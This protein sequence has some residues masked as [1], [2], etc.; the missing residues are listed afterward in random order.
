[1]SQDHTLDRPPGS[2]RDRR[3]SLLLEELFQALPASRQSFSWGVCDAEYAFRSGILVVR[4]LDAVMPNGFH[5]IRDDD[6][7]RLDLRPLPAGEH[8]VYLAMTLC[9]PDE[10]NRFLSGDPRAAAD[11]VLGDDGVEL[12]RLRTRLALVTTP[13]DS[14]DTSL[15]LLKARV[16]RRNGTD[17]RDDDWSEATTFV[18][19][20]LRVKPDSILG[21]RCAS[22]ADRL[23]R[24]ADALA[25]RANTGPA[26]PGSMEAQA[27]LGPLASGLAAFEALLTGQPHPFALYVELCRLSGTVAALR[28][29]TVPVCPPYDHNDA[30]AVFEAVARSF[31]PAA[32]ARV[33]KFTF[34][35]EGQ[36]LRLSPDAGWTQAAAPGSGAQWILAMESDASEEVARRWGENCVIG[37]RSRMP[38]LESRRILGASRAFVKQVDGIRADRRTALF[39]VTPAADTD[40]N[41]DLLVLGGGPDVL[42]TALHLYVLHADGDGGNA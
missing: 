38:R 25:R 34:E 19:P 17:R 22:I 42:P 40:P 37:S 5:V 30:W 33:L 13:P 39:A 23:H 18:P 3:L 12:P 2:S 4:K 36:F 27:Q 11:E 16:R 1:M 29:T 8:A 41:E 21:R 6:R 35:P 10:A 14:P 7:L 31:A 9:P 26:S 15:P 24:D 32:P 20:T 28:R